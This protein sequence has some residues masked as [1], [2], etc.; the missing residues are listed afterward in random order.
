M[1]VNMR[2]VLKRLLCC[3]VSTLWEANLRKIVLLFVTRRK[4][5]G[6]CADTELTTGVLSHCQDG[7]FLLFYL[8]VRLIELQQ[9]TASTVR[10]I[11]EGQGVLLGP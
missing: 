1:N 7:T 4:Y 6:S 3:N 2:D 8:N 10:P 11:A 9:P 5:I